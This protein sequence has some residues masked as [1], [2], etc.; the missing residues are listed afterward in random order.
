[1]VL[2]AVADDRSGLRFNRPINLGDQIQV[3]KNELSIKW[4]SV[5]DP[6]IVSNRVPRASGSPITF[7]LKQIAEMR[8]WSSLAYSLYALLQHF[9]KQRRFNFSQFIFLVKQQR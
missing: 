8:F 2:P 6:N 9:G 5:M 4:K 7:A 3:G 1:M